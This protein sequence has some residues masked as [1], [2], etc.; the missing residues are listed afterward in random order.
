[1][2]RSVST[3]QWKAT[4]SQIRWN[5]LQLPDNRQKMQPYGARRVTRLSSAKRGVP[6]Q[7]TGGCFFRLHRQPLLNEIKMRMPLSCI[8]EGLFNQWAKVRITDAEVKKLIQIA[9]A[10]NKEVLTHL[11]VGKLDLLSTH[12]TNIVNNVYAYPLGNPTQQGD[13]TAVT[14][15]G[16]YN[17]VTGYFQ[18]VRCFKSEEAKFKSIM[19][20]TAKQRT[21]TAFDLC[22]GFALQGSGALSYN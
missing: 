20:G 14:V 12:Y 15:F 17:A 19:D 11:A 22:Q 18:N 16:A 3:Q 4:P 5:I 6:P 7:S 8:R 1:M 10:P 21:Q 2:H 13:T 9:M